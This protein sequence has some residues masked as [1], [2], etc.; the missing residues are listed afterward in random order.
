MVAAEEW[1]SVESTPG[2]GGGFELRVGRA[3][4]GVSKG[5]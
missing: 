1:L 2:F 4:R 5:V 3:R